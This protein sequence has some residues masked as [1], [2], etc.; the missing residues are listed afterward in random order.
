MQ[1]WGTSLAAT[2]LV[3][4]IAAAPCAVAEEEREG[5]SKVIAPASGGMRV[6]IDPE[7]GDFGAAPQGVDEA[8]PL[9]QRA[10]PA[11]E[12]VEE[13]NP[14][15]GY[16]VH[17]QRRFGGVVRATAGSDGTEIEC[18]TGDQPDGR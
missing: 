4:L 18:R 5:S 11:Q 7:T 1:Q 9:L 3:V 16:T 15:G 2:A 6:Y 14:A 12:L 17:L 10:R 13:V 8:A